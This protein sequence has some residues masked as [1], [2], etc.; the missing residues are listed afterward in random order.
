MMNTRVW[1]GTHVG[2]V[3]RRNEDSHGA[4][5]LHATNV[6][7]AVVAATVEGTCL[8][9][10]A[11]GLGGHPCGDVASRL[12]VEHVL[13]AQPAT[14]E[15]L[16]QAL[17]SANAALHDAMVGPDGAPGMGTTAAA[18]LIHDDR[19]AVANVGDSAVFELL[20]D[21]LVQLSVDDVP[22]GASALPGLPSSVVTETLGGTER[23]STITPH[24]HQDNLNENRRFMMCSDGLTNYVPRSRIAEALA[25]ADGAA[26]IAT[27]IDLALAAGGLDNVTVMVLDAHQR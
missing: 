26:A 1:A 3:R 17:R 4:T 11:D 18:V 7:G 9:V 22:A 6:D 27:L 19:V 8:A 14:A 5:G 10:V 16:V 21:R 20:D 23:L 15:A 13:A 24:L 2:N 25:M 12:V